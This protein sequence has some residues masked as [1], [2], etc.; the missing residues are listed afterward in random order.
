MSIKLADTLAPM[1]DFP[2]VE[3]DNVDI[4][5]GGSPKSLQQAYEDGDLGGGGS[6]IEVTS[7]PDASASYLDKVLLY[8]GETGTYEYGKFYKCVSDGETPPSYSWEDTGIGSTPVDGTTIIKDSSTGELSA[9]QATTSTLGVV[10]GGDGTQISNAGGINV[11]NR[12]VVTDTLPTASV[13]Y[14]NAVRLF[15][16]TTGGYMQGGIYMCKLVA[17]SDPAEYTWELISQAE[18]DLSEYKKIFVGDSNA[19][20]QL[21]TAEKKEYDE[22]DITDD[23]ASGFPVVSDQVAD[24]DMN[25]VT[26]NA[27]YDAIQALSAMS[28][29]YRNNI[30]AD[31]N[32]I[33]QTGIYANVSTNVPQVGWNYIIQCIRVS[34]FIFQIAYKMQAGTDSPYVAIR[35]SPDGGTNW[36]AWSVI[37]SS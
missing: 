5:I 1:G 10:K 22:A 35:K 33:I 3:S 11:V 12:L 2:A 13:D 32:N 7:M 34:T 28:L 6:D 24:G 29:T 31:A 15:V 20:S 25:P 37:T 4:T 21:S 16:G 9:V 18:V 17:G 19:W 8:V 36:S 26:S 30:I 23:V 27:T 14:L